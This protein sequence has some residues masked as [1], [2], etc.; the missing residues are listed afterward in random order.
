MGEG[1]HTVYPFSPP[2]ERH[3]PGDGIVTP[4]KRMVKQPEKDSQKAGDDTRKN[5][6]RKIVLYQ[7]LTLT[8]H[9]RY[10]WRAIK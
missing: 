2:A 1:D 9:S 10:N 3:D 8:F 4:G 7:T 6:I 5:I